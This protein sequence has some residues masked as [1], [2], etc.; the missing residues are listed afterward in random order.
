MN[1][2]LFDFPDQDSA[3]KK[4]EEVLAGGEHPMACCRIDPNVKRP[5]QVWDT[6]PPAEPSPGPAPTIEK[7]IAKLSEPE[8]DAL[9]E[10]IAARLHAQG[11][12]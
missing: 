5:Y 7:Q 2:M 8:L 12:Q 9:A 11:T 6:G 10:K 3:H 4:L 1:T